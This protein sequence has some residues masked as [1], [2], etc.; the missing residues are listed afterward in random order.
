MPPKLLFQ[1]R[2]PNILMVL[3]DTRSVTNVQNVLQSKE[4]C[5]I[6]MAHQ[7][8]KSTLSNQLGH[9]KLKEAK[10]LARGYGIICLTV[11][12]AFFNIT[13]S[14]SQSWGCGL[15]FCLF[16]KVKF[17]YRALCLKYLVFVTVLVKRSCG[18][19]AGVIG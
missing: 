19:V 10:F 8:S 12:F 16:Q 17:L 15:R 2:M 13:C 1:Q 7:T 6:S 9:L 11:S 4:Y 14:I 18:L 3:L 5:H